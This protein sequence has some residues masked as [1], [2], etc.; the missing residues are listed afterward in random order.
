MR[1]VLFWFVFAVMLINGICSDIYQFI[2]HQI[3][4]KMP[5]PRVFC[6]QLPYAM[7]NPSIKETLPKVTDMTHYTK[8]LGGRLESVVF[9]YK[10]RLSS[11]MG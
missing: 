11:Y 5:D 4:E 9:Q 7:L 1:T 3:A 6:T 2:Y 10:S 8:W